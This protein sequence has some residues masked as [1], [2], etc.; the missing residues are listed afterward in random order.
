MYIHIMKQVKK[1]D[2]HEFEHTWKELARFNQIYC[3]VLYY[4]ILYCS[5]G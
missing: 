3:S 2:H 1:E 5:I 4:S